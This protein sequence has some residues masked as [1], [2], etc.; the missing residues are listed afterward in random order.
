MIYDPK[1]AQA[2]VDFCVLDKRTGGPDSHMKTVAEQCRADHASGRRIGPWYAGLYVAV[3]NVP[4]AEALHTAFPTPGSV[5]GKPERLERWLADH[6]PTVQL[7]RERRRPVGSPRK[8]AACIESY[9]RW[10][11]E[12]GG[13]L[14]RYESYED[15]W[16]AADAIQF[17]GRYSKMKLLEVL[18]QMGMFDHILPDLRAQDGWSP[19][20]GLALILPHDAYHLLD[21]NNY[22]Q[23]A[24]KIAAE[25][26]EGLHILYPQ[27]HIDTY[28]WQVLLCDFKQVVKTQRQ[29]PGRSTDSEFT[30]WNKIINTPMEPFLYPEQNRTTMWEARRHL[31]PRWAL[32][33]HTHQWNGVREELGKFYNTHGEMWSDAV[34]HYPSMERRA[35]PLL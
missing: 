6:W 24:E 21:Q 34:F 10:I 31:F 13:T 14:H 4:Q 26:Y 2:F 15:A 16:N 18:R 27:L 30:Y 32:A 1:M 20:Q 28:E 11:M 8:L 35:V 7:R 23:D 9:A 29:Y 25:A 3:Y 19:R 33:E 5:A 17:V 22:W 12:H